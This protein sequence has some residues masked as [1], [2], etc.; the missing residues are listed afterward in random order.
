MQPHFNAIT[1][2]YELPKLTADDSGREACR[3]E[4]IH[5][6]PENNTGIQLDKP[7]TQEIPE[8]PEGSN[9][10]LSTISATFITTGLTEN[11]I[12][13]NLDSD[14]ELQKA[15]SC[16]PHNDSIEN[17]DLFTFSCDMK[18]VEV[19]KEQAE[20]V[21]EIKI[22]DHSEYL[23][24]VSQNREDLI[25]GNGNQQ[26]TY[27]SSDTT[28]VPQD[29]EKGVLPKSDIDKTSN[30]H[31]ETS[32]SQIITK[33]SD[34]DENYLGQNTDTE[35]PEANKAEDDEV[36]KLQ[37]VDRMKSDLDSSG[38]LMVLQG[39]S[40]GVHSSIKNQNEDVIGSA[41]LSLESVTEN[42][43]ETESSDS[44]AAFQ[45][46]DSIKPPENSFDTSQD[47]TVE[48]LN[49]EDVKEKEMEN[50]MVNNSD[51]INIKENV[52]L[53][54]DVEMNL[55]S[56]AIPIKCQ[57]NERDETCNDIQVKDTYTSAADEPAELH[58]LRQR[59]ISDLIQK[60]DESQGSTTDECGKIQQTK[61]ELELYEPDNYSLQLKPE[62]VASLKY[63]EKLQ[64]PCFAT[65]LESGITITDQHTISDEDSGNLG[66]L[67][68]NSTGTLG[69]QQFHEDLTEL[70]MGNECQKMVDTV[71]SVTT[72][73]E[74]RPFDLVTETV[75]TAVL[76]A[77]GSVDE[78]TVGMKEF[79]RTFPHPE[80]SAVE[81][82]TLKRSSEFHKPSVDSWV[83]NDITSEKDSL[84]LSYSNETKEKNETENKAVNLEDNSESLCI[85]GETMSSTAQ[86]TPYLATA[87]DEEFP[88]VIPDKETASNLSA[89]DINALQNS[90]PE[91]TAIFPEEA[92]LPL[93][94]D[95]LLEINYRSCTVEVE[96][97]DGNT[98]ENNTLA[99][100]N[101]E[102]I[103]HPATTCESSVC[104]LQNNLSVKEDHLTV[105]SSKAIN[106]LNE[107]TKQ[108]EADE[109]SQFEGSV[110]E[111]LDD[112]TGEQ[113]AGFLQ[114]DITSETEI[115]E[116]LPASSGQHEDSPNSHELINKETFFQ[117]EEQLYAGQQEN[118]NQ[119]ALS[120]V[121]HCQ[122]SSTLEKTNVFMRSESTLVTLSEDKQ[123]QNTEAKSSLTEEEK[124]T[125]T[126]SSS[127]DEINLKVSKT[128]EEQPSVQGSVRDGLTSESVS[129]PEGSVELIFPFSQIPVDVASPA[130][131]DFEKQKAEVEKVVELHSSITR[132]SDSE[133]AFETP[134]S[135]TP[136][137]T[138]PP[139]TR[140]LTPPPPLLQAATEQEFQ[141]DADLQVEETAFPEEIHVSHSIKE[142]AQTSVETV[143]SHSKP[144]VEEE[145]VQ[146]KSP[147]RSLSV[148]FDEDKPIASSGSYNLDFENIDVFHPLPGSPTSPSSPGT[149]EPG[150]KQKTR[151]K[152][153]DS[154]PVS[155]T[156]LSRSL[157]L[158]ASDFEGAS[159]EGSLDSSSKSPEAFSLG[160]DNASGTLK[161][162]KKARTA[163]VKKKQVVKNVA[164]VAD[165]SLNVQDTECPEINKDVTAKELVAETECMTV[166]STAPL[167]PPQEQRESALTSHASYS[168]DLESCERTDPFVSV[169]TRVLSSPP[170]TRKGL[171]FIA[172]PE[173]TQEVPSEDTREEP[174]PTRGQALRLEFD[175]SEDKPEGQQ[176]KTPPPKKLGK[177]PGAKMPLRKPK[178]GSK[179]P[180]DKLDNAPS[181][182][183][184]SQIDVDDIPLPKVS[185]AFDPNHW[186]DPNFNPF[187]SG[188]KL[189]SSPKLTRQTYDYGQYDCDDSIDPF[190]SSTKLATSPPP[191][192]TASFEFSANDNETN[193]ADNENLNKSSKKKKTPIKTMV[194]GVVEDVMSV[195]SLFNTFRVK[196]SPKRSDV[197]SS[198]SQDSTP[199]STPDSPPVITTVDHATDEEKLASSVTSHQWSNMTMDHDADKQDYSQMSDMTPFI[200]ENHFN[201]ESDVVLYGPADEIEYMD[202]IG[203]QSLNENVQKKQSLHLTFEPLSDSPLKSPTKSPVKLSESPTPCSGSSFDEIDPQ[204]LPPMKTQHLSSR[205][206]SSSQDIYSLSPEQSR[207]KDV[208]EV[209]T[210]R[211]ELISPE[212]HITSVDAL[213]TRI[214]RQPPMSDNVQ[215]LDP[216][217]AEKNP[218]VFAQILQEELEFAAMRIE[219]L[220]LAKQITQNSLLCSLDNEQ[221]EGSAP[222]DVSISKSALYSRS[223]ISELVDIDGYPYSQND[224]DSELRK[225]REEIVT[226]EREVTEWKRKY[227]ESRQEVVEMRRIVAEYE[228][229]I[230]QMIVVPEDEQRE[231]VA[232]R[233]TVDQ[234]V[235]E[236]EQALAD[237]NSVE[238]SLADL[239]RRYE[240]MKDVLD[241]FRKN[242][243]VLKKCAQDYLSRVKKEEQRYHALKIHAEEKLDRANAEIAQ[244]R[245]KAQQEQIAYQASLRKEQMKVDSLERTLE[246]KNKEIEELTKI[247]DELIAKMGKS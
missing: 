214:S 178:I 47:H 235:M 40:E 210:D 228:K 139:P 188:N 147:S 168:F 121:G 146:L 113:K 213:L 20:K 166:V 18:Q 182:L 73:S 29:K 124:K 9:V 200:K 4:S 85:V 129:L 105:D 158:Q 131:S 25:S 190:K 94:K 177:K 211:P 148:V 17:K 2:D 84:Q 232:S 208:D 163:S 7:L 10:D 136:V 52:Y 61:A 15:D 179:K 101:L 98:T 64:L 202:K 79:L 185:Y 246:Q 89:S 30:Q 12:P 69:A 137:K 144:P 55:S 119:Q 31:E 138:S 142:V 199:L 114:S 227:E 125:F 67:S 234:L 224:L 242:E 238:K 184:H 24:D 169:S 43:L 100:G 102:Q 201:S 229:T 23:S 27:C 104:S 77:S 109:Y 118:E 204:Q 226:K 181:S 207:T 186:E 157:S 215:Y 71:I 243:E 16:T 172:A 247:C 154:V 26:E 219:A 37:M 240:K 75:D 1:A 91:A 88:R 62:D 164:D 192:S 194:E 244:V 51:V 127:F 54:P 11:D 175:Y 239:F 151:R 97:S 68:S 120:S 36:V 33:T 187:S 159:C 222:N 193:G 13:N 165:I 35:Q 96:T 160:A 5:N 116:V 32:G 8:L 48:E 130:A 90:S 241:G 82:N 99:L 80:E 95:G 115:L 221:R 42:Y 195:C 56:P 153:T 65:A 122:E 60:D 106:I 176:D 140:P 141:A 133:G 231:K 205:I 203:S 108:K 189:P 220:T 49:S 183:V 150:S 198:P 93:P 38:E 6:L 170:G 59:S 149:G 45:H 155:K 245:A 216:E 223:G 87:A 107:T 66:I 173:T 41:C 156:T 110:P 46:A 145:D 162:T 167:E 225:A 57:D 70:T 58:N 39:E 86:L 117:G 76:L 134:E 74:T 83:S 180:V 191:Q 132:S 233:H 44:I 171:S 81:D 3:I 72:E 206:L 143:E 112:L 236:K 161:K 111:V 53:L 63:E 22:N 197:S 196:K 212:E 92:E 103:L 34:L 209:V 218:R 21:D 128:A 230:A 123:I 14:T 152:S 28:S 135:T 19:Y 237:L 126:M 78:D 174:L 50:K 217:L